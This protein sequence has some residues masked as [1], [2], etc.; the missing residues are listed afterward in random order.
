MERKNA[1]AAY[2]R[3]ELDRVEAFARAYCDFIDHGKT[4]RECVQTAER[5]ARA[6]GYEDIR[7]LVAK[8]ARVSAGDRVYCNWMNKSFMMF[9]A[10]RRPLSEGMN[11]LGAHIDSPRIDVKQNPL[12]EEEQIAYLDT[13]YYGGIKKYQWVA[14]PLALHGVIARKDGSVVT[15]AIGEDEGDPV[16]CISD[17]LPHLAQEQMTKDAKSV[18]EGEALN[19]IIGSKPAAE[20]EKDAVKAAILGILKEKYGVEE[21]DFLSAELEIVPAGKARD[22]G[23]DRSMILAYGHDDRV[24]AYPSMQALIDFEGTPEYTLCCILTDK[25]E[26]GSVGATGMDS[27]FFEN[28]VAELYS[29]ME[30][31]SELGLRRALANS[32]MLSSDVSA[33]FDPNFASAFEKKNAA[34]L[35][36][37]VCFNKY[38][39]SRGKSGSS[40]ANAEYIACIRRI[41]D[42]AGVAFQTAELGRV[43][44]GGGGT[45]AYMCAK[46]GMNVID[47]GV[48]VLSMHAPYEV[49]SKADLYEAYKCYLAF[50]RDAAPVG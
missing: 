22:M 50:L 39:G 10:G 24:C 28:V 44:L 36:R 45:I 18:I 43:D 15:V 4:E 37:G 33:A 35:G 49:I 47:S 31:Y 5:A 21:E 19:L 3:A 26:I 25:E 40:D 48:A 23:L 41:L 27:H 11:I 14:M 46:Y 13:H 17:L 32:R 16:F 38:T 9:I 20:E 6:N 42:D 8:G 29:C 30:D 1:W 34:Y 7:R 2:S 12:Y